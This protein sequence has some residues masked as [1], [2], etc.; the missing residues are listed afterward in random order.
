M[1]GMFTLFR[2]NGDDLMT[3]EDIFKQFKD[4]VDHIKRIR[5]LSTP[6][7]SDISGPDEYS[8]VL[9][10]NFSR[11][12]LLAQ[13]N[14]S[15]IDGFIRP[16]LMGKEELTDDARNLLVSFMDLLMNDDSLEEVD[17]HLAEVINSFLFEQDIEKGGQTDENVRINAMAKKVR[18][19]YFMLS[20]LTRF[21][22]EELH[23]IRKKA[24]ENRNRLSLFL[25][26]DKFTSL[27]D[28]AKAN[29][30]LGSL[31]GALLY[32]STAFPMPDE[33]WEEAL[34]IIDDSLEVFNDPFYH[35][36]LPDYEW[37]AYEFRIYYYGSFFAYSYIP[38]HIAARVYDYARKAIDFLKHCDNEFITSSVNIEQ[39]EDLLY[40]SSVLAGYTSA[41]EA[42]E[43][44]YSAY[45]N[46]NPADYSV[47]GVNKNLDTPSLYMSV[48]KMT[49]LELT[50]EDFDR[51]REI[52]KSTLKYIYDIPKRSSVYMKCVTLFSNFPIYYKE[53]PG[54]RSMKDFCIDAFAA[55]HPPTYIHCN[56]VARLSECIARHLIRMEP[57]LFIAFPGCACQ[58]D[59]SESRDRIVRYTYN[60]AL[61]HDMGKLL[62]IDTISMYG[63][64]LLDDEFSLIKSHPVTG[65][66]I[67]KEHHSTREYADVIKGHHLWYDCSRGY[68]MNFDTFKSPY[69]TV[70]DI[71]SIA[72]SLDAATDSVGRSYNTEKTFTEV[73]KELTDGAGSRYAPFAAGL[74]ADKKVCSEIEYL[75]TSGR[76]KLYSETYR[77]LRK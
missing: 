41:R 62:I 58:E 45:E 14:R 25:R 68:P 30:L 31:S 4:Y 12:G 60:A 76:K 26:K 43:K 1:L 3:R 77:A 33:W 71:V 44:F 74:F 65:A 48:V 42:C 49:G 5:R 72:D 70:I 23:E 16:L 8:A 75:L 69:K 36:A 39:E 15:L 51:Y 24:I 10:D 13:E 20:A 40:L 52:E 61:C 28:E 63:R 59:V 67:A 34:S 32:E 50:E 53:V 57:E 37:D 54:I 21:D 19:D 2:K 11:I 6:E 22:N 35:N 7:I 73:I 66:K 55:V 18:Q 47:T 27:C 46:R 64:N 29:V 17:V 56:M 9:E 38:K